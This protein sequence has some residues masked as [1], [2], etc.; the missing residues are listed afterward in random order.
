M[1]LDEKTTA[2]INA[3]RDAAMVALRRDGTPHVTRIVAGLVDGVLVSSGTRSRLRTRLLTRDPRCTLF[4]FE[5][6]PAAG[7]AF[8]GY[9]SLETTVTIHDGPEGLQRSVEYFKRIFGT[10]AD[11]KVTYGGK[12][13]TEDEALEALERDGRILYE[14]N[15][16]RAYGAY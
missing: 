8:G 6:T 13:Y 15:V 12:T 1:E 16:T 4:F 2:Y 14:F 10:T 11:G 9:L 7:R 3:N 5:T